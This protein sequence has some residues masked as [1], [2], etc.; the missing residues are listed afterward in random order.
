MLQRFKW[1]SN[2]ICLDKE[3]CQS[4]H[5]DWRNDW[6]WGLAWRHCSESKRSHFE[7]I[8]RRKI[9]MSCSHRCSFKRIRHSWC[10][11]SHLTWT[12]KRCWN[13]HSLIRKNSL[14]RKERKMYHILLKEELPF[15]SNHRTKSRN[16]FQKD[17]NP[18]TRR[19]YQSFSW[20]CS[21][22]TWIGPRGCSHI[23]RRCSQWAHWI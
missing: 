1:K 22:S 7:E 8:Q 3:W 10:W 15:D 2:H 5:F 23:F 20:R 19:N 4:N 14:S 21:W 11:F 12:S 9:Q 16:H 13:L 6:C 17:W 18:S